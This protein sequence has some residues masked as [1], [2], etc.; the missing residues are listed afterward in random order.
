[1]HDLSKNALLVQAFFRRE[2]MVMQDF[3][4]DPFGSEDS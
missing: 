3:P 2:K 4:I 1:M